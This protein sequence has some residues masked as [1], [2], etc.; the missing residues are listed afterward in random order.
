MKH[1]KL[2]EQ[3]LNEGTGNF[4][5]KNASKIFAIGEGDDDDTAEMSYEDGKSNVEFGLEEAGYTIDGKSRE[6]G[7]NRNFSGVVIARKTDNKSFG[8]IDASVT[9]QSILRSGY[10]QG[11]NFDW[12]FEIDLGNSEYTDEIPDLDVV[13][14]DV[15]YYMGA[16]E[17]NDEI[18][19]KSEEILSWI[20]TTKD[21]MVADIEDIYE[22]HTMPLKVT[23]RFSSGETHYGHD[24][25]DKSKVQK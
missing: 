11:A 15:M 25:K 23:A 12:S 5:N 13:Q 21:K 18:E 20:E 2:F 3:F 14:Q 10:Y 7:E 19:K 16:E 24:P 17:V 22:E 6:P 9:L 8:E 4:Y 1:I